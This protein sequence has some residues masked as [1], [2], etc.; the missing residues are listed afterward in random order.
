M[1]LRQPGAMPGVS[2]FSVILLDASASHAGKNE[3]IFYFRVNHLLD[4][5]LLWSPLAI[6]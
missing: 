2:M 3:E 4:E 5:N 6:P 1:F